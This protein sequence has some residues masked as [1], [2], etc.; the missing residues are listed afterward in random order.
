MNQRLIVID[1][2]TYKSVDEM[3]PDVRRQHEEAVRAVDANRNG[4]PDVFEGSSNPQNVFNNMDAAA[5]NTN[6][7]ISEILDQF[8]PEFRAKYQQAMTKIVANGK[9]YENIDQ[10]PPEIRAKYQQAMGAL[11]ANGNGI[12]DFVEGMMTFPNQ[13][14]TQV[15]SMRTTTPTPTPSKPTPVT[16]SPISSTI[17]PESSVNWM[18]VIAGIILAG[19]CLVMLAAGAW[20]FFLA[21]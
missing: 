7:Q 6:G 2:K 1:G 12:P 14:S 20:Y 15:A 17:E 9:T 8:P 13:P 16:S 5:I 11:D 18:L 10:L 21:K 3:P 4:V 19:T